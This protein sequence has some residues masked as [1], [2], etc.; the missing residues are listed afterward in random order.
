MRNAELCQALREHFRGFNG[1]GAHQHGLLLLVQFG[2]GRR[3][4]VEFFLAAAED[5]VRIILANRGPVGRDGN[6]LQIVNL[7]EFHGFGV[8][9]AGHARKFVV[10]AEIVLKG[11]G[12]QGLVFRGD[13][14]AF[15]GFQ[16]LM[17]AVGIAA[18]GHGAAR[19]FVHD[20]HLVACTM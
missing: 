14:D 15:L 4:G 12:G 18:S 2:N 13:G 5:Q 1:N 9:R 19:E 11:D 10:Q 6:N 7:L 16:S 20:D 3:D 17:Q 8:R